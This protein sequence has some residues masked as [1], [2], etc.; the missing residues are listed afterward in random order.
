MQQVPLMSQTT[1]FCLYRMAG[2]GTMRQLWRKLF[3]LGAFCASLAVAW[4]VDDS[5]LSAAAPMKPA[6]TST[7]TSSSDSIASAISFL[8]TLSMCS[9]TSVK[10]ACLRRSR[11]MKRLFACVSKR[12]T[13]ARPFANATLAHAP[14]A[15]VSRAQGLET[16]REAGTKGLASALKVDTEDSARAATACAMAAMRAAADSF[17]FFVTSSLAAL[18]TVQLLLCSALEPVFSH[19]HLLLSAGESLGLSRFTSST[20][21][22]E[23]RLTCVVAPLRLAD[24]DAQSCVNSKGLR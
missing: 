17:S 20:A 6:G 9:D 11:V 15:N 3:L 22:S 14:H 8:L 7:A 18:A 12:F 21:G 2:T 4:M 19:L 23:G 1:T 16:A 10:S 13:L 5:G 24:A